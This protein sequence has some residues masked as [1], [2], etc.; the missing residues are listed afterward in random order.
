MIVFGLWDG[1]EGRYTESEPEDMERFGS[2]ADARN[3]L[4]Q[5]WDNRG[6]H[7]FNYVHKNPEHA[8]TPSV[9]DDS[10]I[11]LYAREYSE[12]PFAVL[13]IGPQ[14]GVRMQYT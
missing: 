8:E 9:G 4:W 2:L 3:A 13:F 1:G 5:R 7:L 12:E 10:R 6:P 11:R 14:G